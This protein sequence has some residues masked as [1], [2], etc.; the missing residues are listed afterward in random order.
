[1]QSEATSQ[2]PDEA[3]NSSDAPTAE[4][5]A[6]GYEITHISVRALLYVLAGLV[7]SCFVI[8]LGVWHLQADLLR[9]AASEDRASSLIHFTTRDNDAPLLQPSGPMHDTTPAQDMAAMRASEDAVFSRVGWRTP[10]TGMVSVPENVLQAVA[11][12][13]VPT[14]LPTNGGAK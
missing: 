2:P 1:M 7:S 6:R 9:D 5:I 14:T 3:K 10:D 13:P 11:Y 4:A 8:Y 12:R